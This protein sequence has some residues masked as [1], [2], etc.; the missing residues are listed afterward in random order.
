M[1]QNLF[2]NGNVAHIVSSGRI[3]LVIDLLNLKV[4]LHLLTWIS[5]KA[6]TPIGPTHPATWTS[7]SQSP[8]VNALALLGP[9]DL[10][11]HLGVTSLATSQW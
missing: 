2:F 6:Q 4:N 8:A 3:Y 10:P 5:H 9:Y 7:G 11:A 1:I